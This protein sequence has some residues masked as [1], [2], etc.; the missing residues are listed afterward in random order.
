[1]PGSANQVVTALMPL[2]P[3]GVLF[4]AIDMH[5]KARR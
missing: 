4:R 3:R 1:V 2:V 5:R